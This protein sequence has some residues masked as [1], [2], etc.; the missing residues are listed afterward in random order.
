MGAKRLALKIN[1]PNQP[2]G[3]KNATFLAELHHRISDNES[4]RDLRCGE[5]VPMPDA[6]PQV[7]SATF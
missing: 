4:V 3:V 7:P 2:Q 5:I 1:E 6:P